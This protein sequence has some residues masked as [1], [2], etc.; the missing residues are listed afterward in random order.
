M[1]QIWISIILVADEWAA[2]YSVSCLVTYLWMD[3][4]RRVQAPSAV[5]LY[6][7]ASSE[8]DHCCAFS[9]LF[10]FRFHG[11][12]G[13]FYL[14]VCILK[15]NQTFK[16]AHWVTDSRCS[17]CVAQMLRNGIFY[18]FIFVIYAFSLFITVVIFSIICIIRKVAFV[19][20]MCEWL[21]SRSSFCD[22]NTTL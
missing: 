12:D 20:R 17:S 7:S 10:H 21:S 1:T 8:L 6:I 18:V 2:H 4:T 14:S 15:G 13:Q 11:Y 19:Y 16:N 9:F 3:L 5:S 22:F